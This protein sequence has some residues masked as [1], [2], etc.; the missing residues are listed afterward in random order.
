VFTWIFNLIGRRG[1]GLSCG[2]EKTQTLL[3]IENLGNKK[4]KAT[5]SGI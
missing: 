1:D 2:Q 5:A 4:T 3:G